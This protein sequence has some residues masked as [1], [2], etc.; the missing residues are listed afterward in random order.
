MGVGQFAALKVLLPVD[1]CSH[2]I[3]PKRPCT[4]P[5]WQVPGLKVVMPSSPSEA[6]GLL[7]G[8][9]REPDP[10]IFFEPKMLYRTMV[11]EVT[12]LAYYTM[13][14]TRIQPAVMHSG[15]SSLSLVN[16][17]TPM[18]H[19]HP[20]ALTTS[21]HSPIAGASWRLHHSTGCGTRCDGGQ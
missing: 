4:P 19:W 21:C 1:L 18:A 15:Q 9:I 7:L 11:E 8:C 17:S 2:V 12:G 10:C 6:K 5:C 3:Q 14:T 20:S 13:C 16:S